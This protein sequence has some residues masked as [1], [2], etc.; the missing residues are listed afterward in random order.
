MSL[1]DLIYPRTC[2]ECGGP[3][4]HDARYFCWDCLAEFIYVESPYCSLCGDPVPGTIDHEYICFN[5][6]RTTPHFDRARSAVRYDGVA[7]RALR[8]FKYAQATWL[9]RDLALLLHACITTHYDLLQIDALCYVP[10]H[11]VKRRQRGYNQA[12][13]LAGD[14]ARIMRKPVIRRALARARLTESQTNLTASERISNV[15]GVFAPGRRRGIEGRTILLVDD[16]MTTGATVNDCA[17]ALKEAGA[18]AVWVATVA[19]G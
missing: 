3:A 11:P 19:R 9:S 1:L 2:Q 13:L 18:K 7:G 5:C 4:D 17:R 12:Q 14:L 8:A 6:S 10:M 16:V 15:K